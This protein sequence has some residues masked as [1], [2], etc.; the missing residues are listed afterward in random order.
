MTSIKYF[1]VS[2]QQVGIIVYHHCLF[3]VVEIRVT[4]DI[5]HRLVSDAL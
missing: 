5:H 3:T 4:P 1:P 2:E